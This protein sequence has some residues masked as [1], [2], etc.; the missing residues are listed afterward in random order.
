MTY[1]PVIEHYE[2]SMLKCIELEWLIHPHGDH[3]RVAAYNPMPARY[4]KECMGCACLQIHPFPDLI[5]MQWHR[6][7]WHF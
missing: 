4:V 6:R 5:V 1:V 7:E 3:E 2:Y